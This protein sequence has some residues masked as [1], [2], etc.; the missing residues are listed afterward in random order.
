MN[1]VFFKEISFA[2]TIQGKPEWVG[3]AMG[4][5]KE[6]DPFSGMTVNLMTVIS[7]LEKWKCQ[8]QSRNFSC[9]TEFLQQSQKHL[10][11]WVESQQAVLSSLQVRVSDSFFLRF[12]KNQMTAQRT[13]VIRDLDL[14]IRKLTVIW[15]I[16]SSSQEMLVMN[17][18]MPK[19]IS[20]PWD[21]CES[22]I[23]NLIPL[24]VQRWILEDPSA[25]IAEVHS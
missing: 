11:P 22:V 5:S 17:L 6:V 19:E 2:I 18:T 23:Q 13:A 7:W 3:F 12:E 4:V 25:N 9:W 20:M 10:Q 15:E 14:Q 21:K 8:C 1:P 16:P 24:P